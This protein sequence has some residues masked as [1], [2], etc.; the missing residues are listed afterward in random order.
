MATEKTIGLRIQLN[1]V[2]A[3]VKDIK[4][5]EDEIRKGKRRFKRSSN[6]FKNL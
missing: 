2:N 5:F 6:W 1:G 3:V 4:T